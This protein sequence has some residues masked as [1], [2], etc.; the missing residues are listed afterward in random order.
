MCSGSVI[1]GYFDIVRIVVAPNE[2][3]PILIVDANAVLSSA[4][5]V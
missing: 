2:A 5:S 1:I 3:N 4:V